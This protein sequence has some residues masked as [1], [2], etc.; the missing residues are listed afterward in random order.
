MTDFS[1]SRKSL[2]TGNPKGPRSPIGPGR[3]RNP[4]S[5]GG[6]GKPI[7]PFSPEI[8]GDND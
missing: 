2:F 7:S 6:P 5:P 3:P 1:Y 4:V 8:H